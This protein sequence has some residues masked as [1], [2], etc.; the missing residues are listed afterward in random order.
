MQWRAREFDPRSK[1]AWSD[2]MSVSSF[3]G[4]TQVSKFVLV[5][6]QIQ[7]RHECAAMFCHVICL[8]LSF[9]F[10]YLASLFVFIGR[11]LFHILIFHSS[12]LSLLIFSFSF[13]IIYNPV[14][15]ICTT[16]Y[17]IQK[18]YVLPTHCIYV[19]CVDLRTKSDYFP[20][21]H[22]PTGFHN[23][24]LTLYSPVVTICT[25]K[26]IN[27]QFSVLPSQ[28]VCVFC[29]DLRT[30]PVHGLVNW[31]VVFSLIRSFRQATAECNCCWRRAADDWNAYQNIILR[32]GGKFLAKR[33]IVWSRGGKMNVHNFGTWV[34]KSP[35]NVTTPRSHT[36]YCHAETTLLAVVYMC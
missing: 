16:R 23:R 22:Q 24:D 19:F 20:T 30:W 34:T 4:S 28:C 11:L 33:R 13:L 12:F 29:V 35:N 32:W 15:T 31:F 14:V 18:F 8:I 25:A 36:I 21:Q 7:N 5:L 1:F 9:C 6:T 17:N 26:F 2:K 3:R 10:V 27:Q